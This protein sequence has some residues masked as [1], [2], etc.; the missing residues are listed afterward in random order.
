MAL[1]SSFKKEILKYSIT[2]KHCLKIS[3]QMTK[4]NLWNIVPRESIFSLY[5]LQSHLQPVTIAHI[6][7]FYYNIWDRKTPIPLFLM[8]SLSVHYIYCYRTNQTNPIK[9]NLLFLNDC[10]AFSVA[11]RQ[12]FKKHGTNLLHKEI[13]TLQPAETPCISCI[14]GTTVGKYLEG[15]LKMHLSDFCMQS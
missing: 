3:Y 12:Y 6:L 5:S 14:S 1:I 11:G 8:P 4:L 2:L 10:V 9:K 13:T 7:F 15:S